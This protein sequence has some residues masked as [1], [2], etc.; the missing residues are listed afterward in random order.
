M[1]H[2]FVGVGAELCIHC[3]PMKEDASV[4]R[5]VACVPDAA[6]PASENAVA[7]IVCASGCVWGG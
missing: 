1:A 7:T 5:Q 2:L 3:V 4:K 6:H